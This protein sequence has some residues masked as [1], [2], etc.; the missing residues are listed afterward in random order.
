VTTDW[1]QQHRNDVADRVLAALAGLSILGALLG[2]LGDPLLIGLGLAAA[3]A[4]IGPARWEARRVRERRED[5]TDALTGA[6][7][8]A[9][10]VPHLVDTDRGRGRGRV[11]VA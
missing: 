9:R 11:G 5:A 4:V 6:A 8:R 2:T 7:W 3:A 10:H 1:F